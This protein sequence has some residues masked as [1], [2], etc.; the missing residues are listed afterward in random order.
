MKRWK[1]TLC[2]MMALL[3]LVALS[4]CAS[5]APRMV[6]GVQKMAKLNSL[7]SDTTI[8]ADVTLSLLDQETPLTITVRAAGDHQKDPA[9]NAFDLQLSLMDIEQHVLL[10]TMKEDGALT[11]YSSWDNGEFWTRSRLESDEESDAS[12]A[13]IAPAP[14]DILKLALGLAR[15]FQET[16]PVTLTGDDGEEIDGIGYEGVLPAELVQEILASSGLAEKLG[17]D[18]AAQVNEQ[19]LPLVGEVPVKLALEKSSGMISRIELDLTQALGGLLSE[20]IGRVLGEN[21]LPGAAVG[22]TVDGIR[23]IT[24]LSR[25]DKVT[26][27]MPALPES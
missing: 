15:Y 23:S 27:T 21:E 17:E 18:V 14:A 3:L 20:L 6:T 1:K 8:T 24:E 10:Y 19:L 22:L 11:V 9:V 26:V 13:E 4:G 7:H 2:L 12:A 25:F 5:F 16:G